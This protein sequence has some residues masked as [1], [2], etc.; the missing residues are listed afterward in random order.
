MRKHYHSPIFSTGARSTHSLHQPNPQR[1][2]ATLISVLVMALLFVFAALALS[3]AASEGMV[4]GHDS[5]RSRAFY[6]A[7]GSLEVMTRNFDKIFDNQPSPTQTNI[8]ALKNNASLQNAGWQAL[9]PN[10][11]FQQTISPSLISDVKTKTV[12]ISSGPYA[13]L[14]AQRDTWEFTSTATGPT[15][16]QVQLTRSFYSN[17]VPIFQ[18]GVFYDGDMYYSAGG[19]MY[20]GG[21][22][23]TNGHLFLRS[24]DL[25]FEGRVTAAG[26]IVTDVSRNGATPTY[27]KSVYVTNGLGTEYQVTEGS[28]LNG[29]DLTGTNAT[30][31]N[32]SLNN[33]WANFVTQFN[34]NLV[35]RAPKL[36]LPLQLGGANPLE[37]VRRGNDGENVVLATARYYN[38]S[39]IRITLDDSRARLPGGTGGKRLDGNIA[40]DGG[41]SLTAD[42]GYLPKAMVGGY[43]ATRVNGNRFFTGT[44]YDGQP[45]QTWIKVE[46]VTANPAQ[47]DAPTVSDITEDFLSLGL[48]DETAPGGLTFSASKDDRAVIKLQRYAIPGPPIKVTDSLSSSSSTAAF[49]SKTAAGVGGTSRNVYTYDTTNNS[50]YVKTTNHQST[51]ATEAQTLVIA[52]AHGRA[53]TTTGVSVVPFPIEMYDVREGLYNDDVTSSSWNT[54]YNSG[55]AG[56]NIPLRGVMSLVDIDVANLRR[57]MNGEFNTK[58]PNG[59][60]SAAVPKDPRGLIVY[61]SD[62]RGDKDDDGVYDMENT[63]VSSATENGT[64]T[65]FLQANEDLGGAGTDPLV[66]DGVLQADYTWESCRYSDAI[67]SDM[68]AVF[69]HQYYR[70]GVRLIN[71]QQ[72]PG[73]A[74]DGLALA[75][76]NGA[77]VLGNYNAAGAANPVSGHPTPATSYTPP[78]SGSVPASVV[79]DAITVL[80]RA[81]NDGKSFRD[82]MSNNGALG[83]LAGR[84]VTSSYETTVRAAFLM[85]VIRNNV[86][87]TPNQGG[88]ASTQSLDGGVHNFPRFLEDWSP[89]AGTQ[90]QFNYCGSMVS[91]FWSRNSNG[92]F[93]FGSGNTY[94]APD[95]NWTYDTNFDEPTKIPPGTPF[96][97][98]V[99][100][101]GFRQTNN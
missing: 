69:D 75:T 36:R 88:T 22:V 62:R 64:S 82:P 20:V 91:L 71:G 10:Y 80:S 18:F 17:R 73:S 35:A 74:T 63:Y 45:R 95:R 31:P 40:G 60:T 5:A 28:V 56:S 66:P 98:F 78:A 55:S 8:N 29:P 19:T 43:Q 42:R 81:W 92:S 86:T 77:Y 41:D 24:Q 32:G 68:A 9:F 52:T 100:V 47:P 15:G 94:A 48:T 59:L 89:T 46:L 16:A 58:F 26:E 50:S 6:A 23:H 38:K 76:E 54:T 51:T 21:R 65:S 2:S 72:L 96:L 87:T 39:C 90:T 53:T 4:M 33:N 61:V 12:T 67:Q 37:I 85:G 70:R 14:R 1:G 84:R 93:K 34:G 27:G 11:T 25:H 49:T 101:T 83:D 99:Q 57:F 13:G 7:Q 44:S 30:L 79:A 3:R 97:Q